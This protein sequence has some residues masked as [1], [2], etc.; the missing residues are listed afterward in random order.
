MTGYRFEAERFAKSELITLA[1]A[2][3]D[4]VGEILKSVNT[5]RKNFVPLGITCT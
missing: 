5:G 2:R 1:T 3:G 4:V